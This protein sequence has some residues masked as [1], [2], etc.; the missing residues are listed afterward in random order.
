MQIICT[1]LQAGNHASTSLLNLLQDGCSSW[2]PTNSVKGLK[3][4]DT[5]EGNIEAHLVSGCLELLLL[6]EGDA[7]SPSMWS[8][9]LVWCRPG[10]DGVADT[11]SSDANS[12]PDSIWHIPMTCNIHF[13][14]I[15]MTPKNYLKNTS[16]WYGAISSTEKNS[17]IVSL[18]P[19]CWLLPAV[20][21]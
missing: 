2:R 6:R 17:S 16:W 1:S 7:I 21:E 11:P 12:L 4:G 19:M 15:F 13:N 8:S 10:V 20:S 18:I 9:S 5:D 3:A 14:S